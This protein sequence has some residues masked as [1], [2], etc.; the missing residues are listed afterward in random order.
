MKVFRAG[1]ALAGLM[2]AGCQQAPAQAAGGT[3][4]AVN[5]TRWAINHFSVNGRS[6]LDIIGPHQGGGAAV[7][8]G[9][10]RSGSRA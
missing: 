5:H 3:I 1:V 4:E 9:R 8:S 2:L 6:G 10:R 7:A